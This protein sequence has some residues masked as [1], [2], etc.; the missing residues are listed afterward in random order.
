MYYQPTFKEKKIKISNA[1]YDSFFE[2][3]IP[4]QLPFKDKLKFDGEFMYLSKELEG[5]SGGAE[6]KRDG[7]YIEYDEFR[8]RD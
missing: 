7:E 3:S 6:K 2:D 5:Y 4:Y 8:K 1:G